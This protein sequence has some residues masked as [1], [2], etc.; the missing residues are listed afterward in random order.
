M[1][2]TLETIYLNENLGATQFDSDQEET[3]LTTDANTRY[4]IKDM[5][6]KD[7]SGLGS[8][9][10]LE[11]NGFRVAGLT[12][13]ATGS[14][15]VGPNSTLKIKCDKYPFSYTAREVAAISTSNKGYYE[16]TVSLADGSASATIVSEGSS[17]YPDI[18]NGS[19]V[20]AFAFIDKGTNKF[21]HTAASDHNSVQYLN[22]V[23][24][25]ASN[26]SGQN[27]FS[28]YAAVGL[29]QDTS[30]G[31]IGIMSSGDN[32]NAYDL[33][34]TPTINTST[35]NIGSY[36]PYPTSSYPRSTVAYGY[37][38][39]IPHSGYSNAMYAMNIETGAT[40]S[41]TGLSTQGTAGSTDNHIGV[42]L[43]PVTDKFILWR[44]SSNAMEVRLCDV[45]KTVLD[46]RTS[47]STVSSTV[48]KSGTL[49]KAYNVNNP[50]AGVFSP[51]SDGTIGYK[52]TSNVF[53][54]IDT[55]L[56]EVQEGYSVSS[57]TV[58]GQT[59]SAAHRFYVDKQITP[60]AADI[61]ASGITPPTFGVQLL[62]VKSEI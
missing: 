62:G 19:I 58:A 61:S 10:Y 8:N 12:S 13:N 3:I 56:D 39:F 42:T 36:N 17:S 60:T 25:G 5:I 48:L 31:Y 26:T 32:F 29:S 28:N 34:A 59:I 18:P 38:W 4:V 2:D 27:A 51:Q 6:V 50:S 40:V 37:I 44:P 53:V 11:L 21:F 9:T 54:V 52:T 43:D 22:Y 45:T 20:N 24:F 46:A 23:R 33:D 55:N 1:A 41:W 14:L 30:R 16:K 49:S 35:I 15:I 7:T 47:N 57:V